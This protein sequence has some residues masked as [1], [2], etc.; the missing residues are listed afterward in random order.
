MGI[1]GKKQSVCR[2]LGWFIILIG[3]IFTL[4]IDSF[5]L[6]NPLF[7]IGLILIIL[8]AFVTL[9]FPYD[10]I[11][12]H[13]LFFGVITFTAAMI[14]NIIIFP[15][16]NNQEYFIKYIPIIIANVL[17]FLTWHYALSIKKKE[18]IAYVILF[19]TY[20]IL[21]ICFK[22]DLL[23][24]QFNIYT[25]IPILIIIAGFACNFIAETS[26]RKKGLMIYI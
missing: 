21:S 22:L 15:F 25:F 4:I 6:A 8:L 23:I 12:N 5:Y 11:K 18:K 26:M 17:L 10:L 20:L 7:I 9:K 13:R 24:G 19:L 1:V 3:F 16:T 2:F 14:F